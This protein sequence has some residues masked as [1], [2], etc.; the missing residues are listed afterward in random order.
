MAL[1]FGAILTLMAAFLKFKKRIIRIIT[2][3]GKRDSCHQLYKQLQ[4]LPLPSL[5][6]FSL[7]VFVNKNRS[8]FLSNSEIHDRNTRY[9]H[10]LHLP[11]TNLTTVQKAV[12]Y[13]G[14]KIY[15]HLPLNNKMLS[16]DATQF[17]PNLR[18]YLIEH[19]FYSLD[20]YYQ[21]TF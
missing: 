14:S 12:L 9:N 8:L 13:S 18:S 6:I 7:L 5:Y 19:T 2:S 17:T 10:N 1:S 20:E 4:I 11:S 15:N 21:L 16:K 3:A